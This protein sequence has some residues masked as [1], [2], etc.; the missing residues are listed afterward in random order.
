V[1][2]ISVG[3]GAGNDNITVVDV[4]TNGNGRSSIDHTYASSSSIVNRSAD[5]EVI[6]EPSNDMKRY[7]KI[8]ILN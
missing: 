1:Q 5:K 8:K 2:I 4:H 7:K 3:G 6:H